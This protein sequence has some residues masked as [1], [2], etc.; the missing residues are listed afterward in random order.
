MANLVITIGREFGSGGHAVAE[1]L[2]RIMGIK[3][4]DKELI[5]L[6]A[7]ASGYSEE[8]LHDI[9]ETASNSLLYSLS[10][11]AGQHLPL[12]MAGQTMP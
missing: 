6:T 10:L 1:E 3:L 4:Y 12:I 7:K 5:H 11:N 9:D 2:S 8:F